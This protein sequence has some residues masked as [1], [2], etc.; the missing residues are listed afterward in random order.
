M[1]RVN[2]HLIS[3]AA[4]VLVNYRYRNF[5]THNKCFVRISNSPIQSTSHL[6]PKLKILQRNDLV[7]DIFL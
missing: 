7:I 3:C 6:K 4:F 2:F 5:K 1:S